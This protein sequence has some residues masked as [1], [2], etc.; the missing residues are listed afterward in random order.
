MWLLSKENKS[1]HT[2]PI[3]F[4][5]FQK[6]LLIHPAQSY[7]QRK[8]TPAQQTISSSAMIRLWR[9]KNKPSKYHLSSNA[10]LENV[11]LQ[12]RELLELILSEAAVGHNL[13]LILNPKDSNPD[14][15]PETFPLTLIPNPQS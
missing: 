5:S 9:N 6:L 7:K 14:P 8:G 2:F 4:T 13:I 15:Q 10:F 11:F 12:M 3:H 1:V